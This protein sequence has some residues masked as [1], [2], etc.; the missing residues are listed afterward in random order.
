MSGA[1]DFQ[2]FALPTE[3]RH[4]CL[5]ANAKIV[6]IL[7][8]QNNFLRI[9]IYLTILIFLLFYTKSKYS[10][11]TFNFCCFWLFFVGFACLL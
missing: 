7:E 6:L 5:I 4:H 10:I 1:S 2:S 8:P 9:L 11:K 3:L